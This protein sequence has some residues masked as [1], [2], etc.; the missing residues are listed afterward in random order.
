M[1]LDDESL[2]SEVRAG[3]VGRMEELFD[4]HHAGLMRYFLYLTGNRSVSDL[5]E[6]ENR[7]LLGLLSVRA[8]ASKP[9][10]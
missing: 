5:A 8:K 4:R 7:Q 3:D 9:A 6:D 10:A 1:A 2:M